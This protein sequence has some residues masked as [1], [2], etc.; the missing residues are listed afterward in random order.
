MANRFFYCFKGHKLFSPVFK[1]KDFKLLKK[2]SLD[3]SI[4]I[5]KPDKGKGVV[6]LNKTDYINK[7]SNLISDPSKFKVLKVDIFKHILKIETKINNFVRKLKSL[8]VLPPDSDLHISG[9]I[10]GSIYGLP[11]IHKPNVPLRPILSAINSP[12]YKLAK[13]L[14]PHLQAITKNEYTIHDSFHFVDQIKNLSFGQ[15][16]MA[17][18]DVEA[19]YTNIPVSETINI[20]TQSIFNNMSPLNLDP[21]LNTDISSAHFKKLLQ[22]ATEDTIFLFNNILYQQIDGMAMGSPLGPS[23]AN[24]FLAYYESIWIDQ[25]PKSFKPIFYRRYLDDCFIIFKDESHSSLF[26]NY[27]NH[28]HSHIKF[29]MEQENNCSL[30]FLDILIERK[31]DCFQ[32]SV[33]RKPSSTVLGTNFF[34]F[35][36]LR[37][38]HN[39]ILCKIDRAYKICSNWLNFHKEICYLQKKFSTN[40]FPPHMFDKIVASYLDSIFRP[41]MVDFSVPKMVVYLKL[42]FLGPKSTD[43]T[44]LLKEILTPLFPHVDFKYILSNSFNLGSF[45]RVKERIPKLL[46]SSVVYKYTCAS[47]NACYIG[48]TSLQLTVRISKHKGLSF[49]TGLPLTNPEN[50]AI[51]DH[52]FQQDHPILNDNFAIIKPFNSVTDGRILESIYIKSQNPS[53][54]NNISSIRL[55]TV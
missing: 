38:K 44:K 17:S 22:L 33:Y 42:P 20:I 24:A 39:S 37:F 30:P 7:L 19:L 47:C 48:E 15:C 11:K 52:A 2:L 16:Y 4:V 5:T 8:N 43:L 3:S 36:P 13:F 35:I 41:Q 40:F 45:F 18:F 10:P 46:R 29:T 1:F 23:F 28:K 27:L 31:T 12:T 34:S 49:R 6:I 55:Y 21:S 14:V 51:R 32:T 50:S 9:T 25:C 54:N 26:L 53:L